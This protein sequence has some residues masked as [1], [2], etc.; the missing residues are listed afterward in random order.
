MTV[1]TEAE[2]RATLRREIVAEAERD[3][4]G[5]L[6]AGRVMDHVSLPIWRKQNP[7]PKLHLTKEMLAAE[8]ESVEAGMRLARVLFV[9]DNQKRKTRRRQGN[10]DGTRTWTCFCQ[11]RWDGYRQQRA[12]LASLMDL[13]WEARK[14]RLRD[15]AE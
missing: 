4:E 7:L 13:R 3:R 2:A 11:G 8:I 12:R 9:E 6:L 1:R 5:R 14:A 10:M 15:A